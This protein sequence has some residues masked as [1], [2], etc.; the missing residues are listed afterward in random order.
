MYSY[1][2]RIRECEEQLSRLRDLEGELARRVEFEKLKEAGREEY[3]ALLEEIERKRAVIEGE[4]QIR[5]RIGQ[6]WEARRG[7]WE[8]LWQFARARGYLL[9]REETRDWYWE[10]DV[11]HF[12][13]YSR[14]GEEFWVPKPD[15]DSELVDMTNEYVWGPNCLD[16]RRNELIWYMHRNDEYYPSDPIHYLSVEVNR[17]AADPLYEDYRETLAEVS[18]PC[19]RCS[20]ERAGRFMD[21]PWFALDGKTSSCRKEK[22]TIGFLETAFP[23]PVEETKYTLL[24]E[25][26]RPLEIKSYTGRKDFEHFRPQ[27]EGSFSVEVQVEDR[28][29]EWSDTI[30]FD[31]CAGHEDSRCCEDG[32]EEDRQL[33]RVLRSIQVAS[34]LKRPWRAQA[35]R[36]AYPQA[37]EDL[38]HFLRGRGAFRTISSEVLDKLIDNDLFQWAL[39]SRFR[40]EAEK[41][42]A[43]KLTR[44]GDDTDRPKK[45]RRRVLEVLAVPKGRRVRVR[46]R[47]T[48]DVQD[49]LPEIGFDR[50][51]SVRPQ[52]K[53]SARVRY[54]RLLTAGRRLNYEGEVL[55]FKI[56]YEDCFDHFRHPESGQRLRVWP[57]GV[58]PRPTAS[59]LEALSQI[60]CASFFP[61]STEQRSL[62]VQ[63]KEE[64]EAGVFLFDMSIMKGN[65]EEDL[66]TEGTFRA[67]DLALTEPG[68][69]SGLGDWV[70]NN[71]TNFPEALQE[72]W[73]IYQFIRALEPEIIYTMVIRESGVV[74]G[75][76]RRVLF[77]SMTSRVT[78]RMSRLHRLYPF[79]REFYQSVQLHR[80]VGEYRANVAGKTV[81]QLAR[82]GFVLAFATVAVSNLYEEFMRDAEFSLTR[83]ISYGLIDFAGAYI[84]MLGGSLA[85]SLVASLP[86]VA[87]SAP[88]AVAAVV[89]GG[90]AIVAGWAISNLYSNSDVVV[91]V[92]KMILEW[93]TED[94]PTA[95]LEAPPLPP[96][97]VEK[98]MIPGQLVT[99]FR[100]AAAVIRAAKE[101]ERRRKQERRDERIRRRQGG[102]PSPG[103]A[104][105]VGG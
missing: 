11:P 54:R 18:D 99:E 101:H 88:V 85:A 66:E 91:T 27:R 84:S 53:V 64:F 48:M 95:V 20:E 10:N 46:V 69:A 17:D 45:R 63:T 60:C 9:D 79:F 93:T 15:L 42:L 8:N 2:R 32:I 36:D 29:Y 81:G 72:A 50:L 87:A 49:L 57:R 4:L 25:A 65:G 56:H 67:E 68:I 35:W 39:W 14:V 96:E 98:G 58:R 12:W 41:A 6:C 77:F 105:L 21:V 76:G 55:D 71:R 22:I 80:F 51:E 40:H 16:D 90:T 83:L 34:G 13:I 5:R 61:R 47:F 33:R 82:S 92:K 59:D 38:A 3:A 43:A 44:R 97:E 30:D 74:T 78:A 103:P 24:D 89:I 19:I 86:I 37:A 104:H 75:P 100:G 28:F 26:D 7:K 73:S 62:P 1:L 94:E 23:R 31:V 70:W 102:V 52:I